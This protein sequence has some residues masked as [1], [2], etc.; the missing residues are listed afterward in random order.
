MSYTHLTEKERY[1]ISHLKV[2]K[3]SLRE[4]ARRLGRHHTSISREIKRNGPTHSPDAVYWYYFTQPVAAKRSRLARSYRRQNNQSLVKYVDE[5]LRLDWP[6]EAIAAR[7][8]LDYPGNSQMRISH[9]TIYRWIYLDA[10]QDGDLHTHLRR[11]HK[12]RRRQ[13]R[14][15]S[16]LRCIP[17]RVSIDQRPAIVDTRERFGDWEGDSVEGAKGTG[18]LATHVERKSRYLM[19]AK[20]TDKKAATMNAQSIK[21]FWQV[22]RTM[23]QTLTV[24]NGKEFSQFKELE[25]KTGLT[26]Y[27]ADPYSAWQRGTNENTNGL[28]R[29]YFPKGIDFQTVSEED[30]D[31]TVKKVNHRPRKCLNYLTPHEVFY[32]ASRGALGT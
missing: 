20:L 19:A 24:D 14:Y 6:P 7:L 30:L 16:G 22:P 2:A 25:A 12:K 18:C 26:V 28:L 21:S 27:F 13:K 10:S 32:Q 5:K 23:R 3:F 17:G 31:L 8:R 15:G 1:V 4:I 29:H 11:R 9:E